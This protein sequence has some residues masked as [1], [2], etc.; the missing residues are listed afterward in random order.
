MKIVFFAAVSYH[1]VISGRTKQLALELAEL[2]HEIWFV[3]M[4]SLRNSRLPLFKTAFCDKIHV[5]T[6]PPFPGSFVLM[7]SWVGAAWR[8]VVSAFLRRSLPPLQD[9]HCIVSNPWWAPL[10]TLLPFKTLCYDCIDHISVHCGPAYVEN[11]KAW[12]ELLLAACHHVFIINDRLREELGGSGEKRIHL[13]PNG[14]PDAWLS[15]PSTLK[16]SARP[17][18]GFIGAIYEWVDQDLIAYAANALKDMDFVLIGPTRRQVSV[19][20]LLAVANVRVL[21][22]VSFEKVPEQI[23]SMDV[24]IIP[25]KRDVVSECADPLKLYEYLALGKP[26]VSSVNFNITAPIYYVPTREEFVQSILKAFNEKDLGREKRRR[27]AA[28][29]S[30]RSQ[31]EKLIRSLS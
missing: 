11:M 4:P 2:G 26:V 8:A 7:S 3:E 16:A 22:P 28:G 30:W 13:I 1:S 21:P 6:L 5:L 23:A 18:I 29:Y 24:C 27:Y 17:R 20:K 12:E 10:L 14:V 15:L 31:A 9:V 19:D 25:F